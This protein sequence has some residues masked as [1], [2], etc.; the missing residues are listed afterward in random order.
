MVEMLWPHLRREDDNRVLA[1]VLRQH[2][3]KVG[4]ARAQDDFVR[5]YISVQSIQ[6]SSLYLF[7]LLTLDYSMFWL[8]KKLTR[9]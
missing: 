6:K 1:G 4:R 2:Q 7:V 9:K 3:L 8:V 5:L